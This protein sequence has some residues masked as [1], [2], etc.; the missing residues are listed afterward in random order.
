[1]QYTIWQSFGADS[2]GSARAPI[3]IA[4][5]ALVLI[6]LSLIGPAGP[7][8]LT[9]APLLLGIALLV[10]A[11]RWN[12]GPRHA[13]LESLAARLDSGLESIKDLQWEIREREARYRDLLDHQDDVIARRDADGMLSFVNDAF[14]KTFGVERRDVLGHPLSLPILD[15]EATQDTGQRNGVRDTRVVE[16]S[17]TS[18][19]RWFVWEDSPLP[20]EHGGP[21]E[22]QSIGRDVT[23]QRAAELALAQARDQAMTASQA[24]SR[25]LASM[26]HEIRTPMNGILGM[27]D[28]LLDTKLSPEQMTYARAISTSATTLLSLI[29]EVLDFSKIE[30]GK[31]DLRP[32]PFDLTET[33]QG[34]V[35]LLGPRARDKGLEIGWFVA[36]DL[37]QTV[38]GDQARI[39]QVLMNLVGNAIKFTEQGGVALTAKRAEDSSDPERT[40]VRFDV[41]DTGPGVPPQAL[42]RIFAEFEQADQAPARRHGGTGLGLAISKGLVRAMGGQ[43]RVASEP[44]AGATFTVE[45]P[46]GTPKDTPALRAAWPTPRDDDKVLILLDGGTEAAVVSDLITSMGASATRVS[47]DEAVR[48][49]QA[50]ADKGAPYTALLTDTANA[51]K[52]GRAILPFLACAPGQPAPRAVVTIDP[53][54][55]SAYAALAAQGF[56]AYLVR[57]VRPVSALTQLFA[58]SQCL[59][60]P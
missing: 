50:A 20:S 52:S 1:M 34:V 33:A 4:C 25:F 60:N 23:E 26:S 32:A 6:G 41:T 49:A 58:R 46:L 43:I 42:E 38:V 24:K 40:V 22:I 45:L 17:T 56:N 14:C 8:V 54:E 12:S 21:S 31:T 29:D 57:P 15:S 53:G 51:G 18:G 5:L 7:V 3:P 16:L 30:A 10:M 27:T 11:A 55:R 48:V 39:R 37:P 9:L 44:G 13:Q 47:A 36:P 59:S 35:E 2:A 19:P 28:L